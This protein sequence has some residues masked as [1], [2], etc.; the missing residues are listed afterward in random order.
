ML[1]TNTII[2]VCF[3]GAVLIGSVVYFLYHVIWT[4]KLKVKETQKYENPPSTTDDSDD[5][6]ILTINWKNIIFVFV[7]IS[8]DA[9]ITDHYFVCPGYCVFCCRILY[10]MEDSD[11]K[12]TENQTKG[13][14]ETGRFE[15]VKE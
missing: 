12:T 7:Y 14:N 6:G 11:I 5:D 1:D 4:N 13:K 2:F 8:T 9:G 3:A 10:V 15:N